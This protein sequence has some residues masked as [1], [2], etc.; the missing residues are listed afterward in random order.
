MIP[1]VWPAAIKA[2]PWRAI[3][4][5]TVVAVVA[6]AGWRVS[7]WHDAYKRLQATEKAL[8][9][10]T[11]EAQ[12]CADREAVAALAYA[13]AARQAESVAA[14]DKATAERIQREL[15]INLAAADRTGRDL[16]RRLRD[17]QARRC[18]SAVPA[19]AGASVELTGTA[20]EPSVGSVVERA[21]AEHFAACAKDA[22]RLSGWQQWW[23]KVKAGRKAVQ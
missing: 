19:A 3:G 15:Q 14:A 4:A 16:A 2:L 10:R 7:V 11:A 22:E 5:A 23:T 9:T 8:A 6:F 20:G 1:L 13:D 18:G 12:Q 21:T 17:Y